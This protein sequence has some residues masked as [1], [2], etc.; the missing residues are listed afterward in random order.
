ML[1]LKGTFKCPECGYQVEGIDIKVCPNCTSEEICLMV[2]LEELKILPKVSEMAGSLNS[3]EA[4]DKAEEVFISATYREAFNVIEEAKELLEVFLKERDKI[5]MK[6]EELRAIAN[7]GREVGEIA[8]TLDTL[9]KLDL[10]I[11]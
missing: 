3:E 8:V 7:L 6:P 2:S 9:R 11:L 4:L 1:E 5:K 10:G